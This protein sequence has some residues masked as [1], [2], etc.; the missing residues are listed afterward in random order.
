MRSVCCDPVG[1]DSAAA[2]AF[3]LETVFCCPRTG[4]GNPSPNRSGEDA[5]DHRGGRSLCASHFRKERQART[6]RR[7]ICLNPTPSGVKSLFAA[8]KK[9]FAAGDPEDRCNCE[10]ETRFTA[11][12]VGAVEF[13]PPDQTSISASRFRQQEGC[14]LCSRTSIRYLVFRGS[15]RRIAL[16][17]RLIW[18]PT[19]PVQAFLHPP[20]IFLL[21]PGTARPEAGSRGIGQGLRRRPCPRLPA[22][23]CLS[24]SPAHA[25]LARLRRHGLSL[26]KGATASV[27]P[28][29]APPGRSRA[30]RAPGQHRQPGEARHRGSGRSRACRPRQ[31]PGGDAAGRYRPSPPSGSHGPALRHP[32]HARGPS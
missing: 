24:T 9:S 10:T 23:A 2:H 22:R 26:C 1:P 31:M 13:T 29:G 8:T 16:G 6:A 15:P 7:S 19:P 12:Q 5:S 32:A 28:D 25:P 11:Y 18:E 17:R 21:P 14:V 20:V 30:R 3:L 4:P 27:S